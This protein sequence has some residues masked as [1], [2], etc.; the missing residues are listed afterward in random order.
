MVYV[1]GR[2]VLTAIVPMALWRAAKKNSSARGRIAYRLKEQK[3]L[4]MEQ[5]NL[6]IEGFTSRQFQ[7]D[8]QRHE[9]SAPFPKTIQH[10]LQT[11]NL[12]NDAIAKENQLL[13]EPFFMLGEEY[14]E[15][16]T[17]EEKSQ[18]MQVNNSI[19]VFL[20]Q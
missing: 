14:L 5:H 6:L 1:V 13:M 19:E 10:F 17:G 3:Y 9:W 8:G 2:G 16:I 4:Q 18:K 11:T 7:T 12:W 20:K 15:A